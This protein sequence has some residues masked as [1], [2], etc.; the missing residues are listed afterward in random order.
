[1]IGAIVA[2]KGYTLITRN[3]EHLQKIEELNLMPAP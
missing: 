2:E 1:M 3:L